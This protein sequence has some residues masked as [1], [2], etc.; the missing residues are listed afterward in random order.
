MFERD[1]THEIIDFLN[2]LIINQKTG[3]YI[4]L[5]TEALKELGKRSGII[6]STY[7]YYDRIRDQSLYENYIEKRGDKY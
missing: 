5:Y 2:S 6:A 7:Q 3:T 4:N 1:K